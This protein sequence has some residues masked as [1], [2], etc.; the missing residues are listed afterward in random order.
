VLL[1]MPM[2]CQDSVN[3]PP[4]ASVVGLAVNVTGRT[5]IVSPTARR[6]KVLFDSSRT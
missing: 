1:V 2:F 3:V 4:G 6:L 5:V